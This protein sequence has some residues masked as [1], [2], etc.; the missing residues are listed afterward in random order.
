MGGDIVLKGMNIR[1][2]GSDPSGECTITAGK[3]IAT[4]FAVTSVSGTKVNINGTQDVG[5]S[6]S[7]VNG[8]GK[9]QNTQSQA[10]DEKQASFLGQIMQAIKKFKQLLECA[11]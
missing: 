3:Q 8:H 6:G 2:Q 11:S 10:T 7:T 5:I 4:S 9:L 1:I